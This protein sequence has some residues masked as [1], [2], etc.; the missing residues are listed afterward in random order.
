[1]NIRIGSSVLLILVT[2]CIVLK[3]E[4]SSPSS[5]SITH[6]FRNVASWLKKNNLKNKKHLNENVIKRGLLIL[7]KTQLMT[8]GIDGAA[9]QFSSKISGTSADRNNISNE[10]KKI[11]KSSFSKKHGKEKQ[12]RPSIDLAKLVHKAKSTQDALRAIELIELCQ[13]ALNIIQENPSHF[14]Q[15]K[16]LGPSWQSNARNSNIEL[17]APPIYI[18][19]LLSD[20][21]KSFSKQRKDKEDEDKEDDGDEEDDEEGEFV[22]ICGL[23]LKDMNRKDGQNS[24]VLCDNLQDEKLMKVLSLEPIHIKSTSTCVS[25]TCYHIALKLYE[26]LKNKMSIVEHADDIKVTDDV[27]KAEHNL[28]FVGHSFAGSVAG[29]TCALFN[30]NIPS[31]GLVENF[32]EDINQQPIKEKSESERRNDNDGTHCDTIGYNK[33]SCLLIGPCP[34]IGRSVKLDNLD[35]T[36]FVLGDD[37]FSRYHTKSMK[38]LEN[39]LIQFLPSKQYEN[40]MNDESEEDDEED[41]EKM[42]KGLKSFRFG[43][44]LSSALVRD[45]FGNTITNVKKRKLTNSVLIKSD[46]SR[47]VGSDDE[48]VCPGIVYMLKPRSSGDIIISTTKRGGVSESILW[49]MNDIVISKSMLAHHHLN[50]YLSAFDRA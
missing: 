14:D 30:N 9:F 15:D 31:S 13:D 4:S 28:Q 50:A 8:K 6:P 43:T 44:G 10:M 46:Q 49:Q 5:T 25:Q 41:D 27:K 47:D 23:L 38:R 18:K 42:K 29:L 22:E 7:D 48:L 24:L 21:H 34:C 39:R 17:I 2:V 40:S 37:L 12:K 3:V 36:S 33:L 11:Q 32:I 20:I 26:E 45:A 19:I 1:M 16:T 35:I